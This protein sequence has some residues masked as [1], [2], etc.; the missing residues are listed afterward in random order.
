MI[1]ILILFIGV[2]FLLANMGFNQGPYGSEYFDVAGPFSLV[3][4][5]LQLGDVNNDDTVNILD[6]ISIVNLIIGE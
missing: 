1:R 5:N 3:D 4:M 6:I 2:S